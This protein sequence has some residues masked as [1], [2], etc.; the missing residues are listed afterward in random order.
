MTGKKWHEARKF[1]ARIHRTLE[2]STFAVE[3]MAEVFGA[4]FCVCKVREKLG[5]PQNDKHSLWL[6][7]CLRFSSHNEKST[8]FSAFHTFFTSLF[9][10]SNSEGK[11]HSL[12]E[13]KTIR[14]QNLLRLF[15]L[16]LSRLQWILKSGCWSVSIHKQIQCFACQCWCDERQP[17]LSRWGEI[18]CESTTENFSMKM[19]NNPGFVV[20]AAD[21]D[22]I[23]YDA[24]S[25]SFSRPC[26]F[27]SLSHTHEACWIECN[28][29][30]ER[31]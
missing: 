13:K 2:S 18:F 31:M 10:L 14:N 16:F 23:H 20:F 1:S 4:S 12:S 15:R 9:F 21:N 22:Y 25:F 17:K 6:I 8:F 3:I 19:R 5:F 28:R 27:P 29:T 30:K 7:D 26:R 11:A 24:F